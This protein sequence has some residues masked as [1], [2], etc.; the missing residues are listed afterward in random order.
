MRDDITA[1]IL[2]GGLGTRLRSE[3]A[4]RPKVLAE[5]A[6]QPF[7]E[8]IFQ[9]LEGFGITK[10]VLCVGYMA[11]KIEELYGSSYGSLSLSYSHE[12]TLLGTAGAVRFALKA[13]NTKYVLVL[14][15][16]SF[17]D[18]E[19]DSFEDSLVERDAEAA[20]VLTKVDDTARY[21]SVVIDE[22]GAITSFIE[23]SGAAGAGLIN[24]GVYLLKRSIVAEIPVG[25]VLSIEKDVFPSWIGRRF[26]GFVSDS[27]VFIDIGTPQSF[28]TAQTIFTAEVGK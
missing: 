20:V 12:N 28:H 7:I 17:C 18:F 8:R 21:G 26:Y 25:R 14:N 4:D 13:V 16:D 5:V 23:K 27:R 19:L 24:A 1:V 6:G 2:A 15:G 22:S 3:V 10:V 9:Q 11:D